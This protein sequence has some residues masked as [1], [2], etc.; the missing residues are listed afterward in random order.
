VLA[1]AA[2][3]PT[4]EIGSGYFQETHPESLFKDCSDYCELVSSPEQMPRVL[5]IAIRTAISKRGVAVIV[6][7][8]DVAL[9]A[10]VPA[11]PPTLERMQFAQP[12]VTPPTAEIDRVAALLNG[13]KRIS[14]LCGAGCT[15][16]R[17]QVRALAGKL[18]SPVVS[19]LRG[20]EALEG[21]NPYYV[22]LTGLIGYS[23]GYG[24]MNDCDVLVMLGTDF[25]YRQ[26]YPESQST[27]IVQ[28]D[29]RPENIGRR[30]RVDHGLVGDVG[31]TLDALL[32]KLAQKTDTKHAMRAVEHYRGV[33]KDLDELAIGKPGHRPVHPQQVAKA[34]SDQA[35]DDAVFTCDVGLPTVWAARYAEMNGGRRR[36]IGSF[37]QARWRTPWRK[38]SAHRRPSRTGK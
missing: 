35:S 36:L 30:T 23:S 10:A 31:A 15:G 14:L 19:A 4:S 37:N 29:I 9:R 26:F 6:L 12:T 8:G 16:A 7:P 2:Q 38:P 28:I 22:G 21:D 27:R 3:I 20:K 25:P 13:A 1:I 5:E 32:P 34:L 17:D 24:A 11:P 33:R 18:Q